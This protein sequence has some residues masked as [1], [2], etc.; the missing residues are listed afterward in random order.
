MIRL[1]EMRVHD[2]E[3]QAPSSPAAAPRA[4]QFPRAISTLRFVGYVA[5]VTT[6]CFAWYCGRFAVSTPV[7]GMCGVLLRSQA[8]LRQPLRGR[9]L[10]YIVVGMV[11]FV[12]VLGFLIEGSTPYLS[13]VL[14]KERFD[15]FGMHPAS[16]A[17]AWILLVYAGAMT[18]RGQL[19][20]RE[21]RSVDGT[22]KQ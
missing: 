12:G 16:I 19:E 10:L 1:P 6:G 4:V 18:W 7:L 17:T 13:K 15:A 9:E 3:T 14:T 2:L 11:V 22:R 21:A 20:S 8:E 5:F